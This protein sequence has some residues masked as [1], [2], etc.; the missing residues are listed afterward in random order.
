MTQIEFKLAESRIEYA[1]EQ[2]KSTEK[3]SKAII[4]GS[5]LANNYSN[6]NEFLIKRTEEIYKKL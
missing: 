3:L 4:L 1:I 2:V 5:L 6:T